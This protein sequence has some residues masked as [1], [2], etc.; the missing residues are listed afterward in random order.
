MYLIPIHSL[1]KSC[2]EA[3]RTFCWRLVGESDPNSEKRLQTYCRDRDTNPCG[4]LYSS[5]PREKGGAF[6]LWVSLV[7]SYEACL[8]SR[9]TSNALGGK[10]MVLCHNIQR[11]LAQIGVISGITSSPHG[12]GTGRST[13]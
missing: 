7:S 5:S 12:R 2:R 3:I 11:D 13:Y 4:D 8:R 10:R 6:M 9:S 1:R